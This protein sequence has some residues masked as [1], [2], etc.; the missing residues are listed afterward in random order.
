MLVEVGAGNVEVLKRVVVVVAVGS[1]MSA[2]SCQRTTRTEA[3]NIK[4]R[5]DRMYTVR[6]DTCRMCSGMCD[7]RRQ[8]YL[9]VV[10]TGVTIVEG[11]RV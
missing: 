3:E 7:P 10:A 9:L 2:M 1:F 8:L 6:L 5:S 4:E 11:V